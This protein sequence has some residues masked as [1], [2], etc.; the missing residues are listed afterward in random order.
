MTVVND[1]ATESEGREERAN[2][3]L[4]ESAVTPDC[5][6]ADADLESDTWVFSPAPSQPPESARIGP[7]R[8]VGR[9]PA[10]PRS[11]AVRSAGSSSALGATLGS[12]PRL[13]IAAVLLALPLTAILLSRWV[14]PA[15]VRPLA[16]REDGTASQFSSGPGGFEQ[17]PEAYESQPEPGAAISPEV[18]DGLSSRYLPPPA[19]DHAFVRRRQE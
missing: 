17:E 4:T 9:L 16:P 14:G 18:G 15:L 7:P 2:R 1:V 12:H 6:Q 13:T 10:P 8:G 3:G 11:L 5:L 19:T